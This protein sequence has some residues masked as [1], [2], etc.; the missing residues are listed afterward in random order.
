MYNYQTLECISI[1][2]VTLDVVEL[3]HLAFTEQYNMMHNSTSDQY[4]I[5][6]SLKYYTA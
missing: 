3:M 2:A 6:K 5:A 4:K 1:S